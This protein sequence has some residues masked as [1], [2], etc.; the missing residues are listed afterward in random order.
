MKQKFLMSMIMIAIDVFP[1]FAMNQHSNYS[2]LPYNLIRSLQRGF[3]NSA[4]ENNYS[5]RK[6]SDMA[7]EVG[8]QLRITHKDVFADRRNVDAIVIYTVIANDPSVLEELIVKDT[9]GYFDSSMIRALRYYFA[10]NFESSIRE[11]ERI[12]HI[13]QNRST[14]PYIYLMM[15]KAMM[16]LQPKEAIRFFD[17]IRLISPGTILE[18]MSLRNLLEI[19]LNHSMEERSFGYIRD[20]SRQFHHSI[21]KDHFIQLLLHFFLSNHPKLQDD[22][23]VSTISFLDLKDQRIV[24]FKIA[25][26]AVISGKNAIGMLSIKQLKEIKNE[27]DYRDLAAI[28]LYIDILNIPFIDMV[29]SQRSL[30]IIPDDA[31]TPQDRIL[32]KASKI[33]VLDMRETLLDVHIKSTDKDLI[34]D[35]KQDEKINFDLDPFIKSNRQKIKQIDM[36]LQEGE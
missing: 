5:Q 32:K 12:K 29:S 2:M 26:Y 20:Y 15:G 8:M 17:H 27:L 36:L 35:Q 34:G 16:A 33:V 1:S 3:D 23:I 30:S 21:H 10:G 22:D 7:Q 24:Y 19:T 25:R 4:R 31:L 6:L 13:Y 14:E 18:E 11:F 28:W 9:Q